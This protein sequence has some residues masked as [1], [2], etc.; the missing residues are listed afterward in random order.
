MTEAIWD[1][2]LNPISDHSQIYSELE[3]VSKASGG[4]F[5]LCSAELGWRRTRHTEKDTSFHPS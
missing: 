3:N 2:L 5:Q 1:E 4:L